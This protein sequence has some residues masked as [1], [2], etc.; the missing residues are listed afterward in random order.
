M[1]GPYDG[2]HSIEHRTVLAS[3]HANRPTVDRTITVA[4]GVVGLLL[5]ILSLLSLALA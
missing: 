4:A 1:T 5:V 3:F 2:D